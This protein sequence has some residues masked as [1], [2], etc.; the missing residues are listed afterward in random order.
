MH[1]RHGSGR[2]ITRK[3][4]ESFSQKRILAMRKARSKGMATKP[5]GNFEGSGY[6]GETRPMAT[7]KKKGE[8]AFTRLAL[9]G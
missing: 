4:T 5:V 7:Q 1:A 8:P 2:S 9:F 6:G 3:R